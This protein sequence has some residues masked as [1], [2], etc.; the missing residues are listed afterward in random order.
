[1][2]DNL[3]RSR[4]I[5]NALIQWYPGEPTGN[6]ARHLTTLAALISGLVARTSSQLPPSLRRCPM[7]ANPRAVSHAMGG[8]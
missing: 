1:M 4:A 3:R 7:V 5:H 2:S 6:V 8:G